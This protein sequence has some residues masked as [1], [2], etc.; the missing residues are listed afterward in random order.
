[1][2]CFSIQNI[3]DILSSNAIWQSATDWILQFADTAPEGIYEIIGRDM[4]VNLHSYYTLP[5]NECR[6]E[7]HLHYIDLQYCIAGG[8]RIEHAAAD[9]LE[10]NG[11]YDAVKDFQYYATSSS[12]KTQMIDLNPG[13]CGIF[14]PGEAHKP[15]I[16]NQRDPHIKKLVVKIHQKLLSPTSHIIQQVNKQQE[17]ACFQ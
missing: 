3:P 17:G 14:F 2:H 1:M 4:Y 5:F 10:R 11:E 12:I 15:K 6:F 8:E 9:L 16:H 7:S 13:I